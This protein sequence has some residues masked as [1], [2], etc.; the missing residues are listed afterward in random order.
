MSDFLVTNIRHGMT[1][2]A[3]D[4]RFTGAL[5]VRGG[6]IT[7]MGEGLTAGPDERVIDAGGCVVTPGL[8]NTHHHLF[9]SLMKSIPATLPGGLDEWVMEGPYRFWPTLDEEAMRASVA[10]GLAELV[11]SGTTTV[12]D[13]HYI[14][15]DRYD[16]D[17]A[18]VL[19]ETANAF[20]IRFVLG[21]GG[22]TRGRPW[23]KS[24]LPPAPTETL[25]EMLA[26]VAAAAARWHDPSEFALTRV[27]ATPVTTLFNLGEGEVREVA[28]AARALGLRMHTHLSENETYVK[29]SL[30]RFGLRPVEWMAEQEWIGSDIWFAHLVHC[31]DHELG[32]LADAGTG[33]AHCPQ[34]NARLGSGIANAPRFSAL[35][36]IV[37][38]GVDGTSANEA[39]DMG[40]A[41]YSAFTIHRAAQGPGATTAEGVLHWATGGGA[42]ALGFDSVGTLAPGKAA[43]LVLFDLE[44]PRYF[45]QHDRTIAPVISGGELRVRHSF[46]GGSP[47]VVDGRVPWLD[48]EKLGADSARIV[49]RMKREA[50]V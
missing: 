30:E 46:V 16:Y 43:D 12:S 17:P 35:G 7:E 34:S 8:V 41:L 39:G 45:G 11:L 37:S 50:Y 1:G 9:Q 19:V 27:A 15:S 5:R 28:Q 31:E 49:E 36:G 6:V 26:G 22:L 13:L 2:A 32:M 4:A 48:L 10:V 18:E 44:H 21:R 24:D 3:S 40:Q 23:H 42:A 25:D 47:L 33:M 14:F 29:S 38:L 20:G